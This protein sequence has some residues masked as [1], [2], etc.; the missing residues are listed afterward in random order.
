MHTVDEMY[1]NARCF[2]LSDWLPRLIAFHFLLI[3]IR[4]GVQFSVS[5][6]TVA[7]LFIVFL[8]SVLHTPVI[9]IGYSQLFAQ[10]QTPTDPCFLE[11]GKPTRCIPPFDNAAFGKHLVV[12]S[13]C[14][15]PPSRYCKSALD[16]DGELRRS[17]FICDAN[18]QKR[19]HPAAYMT[20]LNNP[21]NITC[22]MSEPFVEYPQNV[23]MT[24][25]LGKKFELTY[26]SLQ[27]CSTRPESMAIYKS[28]D[29]GETWTPF[30]YYSSNCKLMYDKSPR[31]TIS[32]ANEQAALCTE[33]YSHV[34][35]M[36]WARVAFSTLESRPSAYNFDNSP[37]LQDWVTATD[38]KVIFNRL[39]TYDDDVLSDKRLR[40]S[41]YYSLSDFA[42]G[43]RCKCN[44]H[45]SRCITNRDG[46]LVCDCKH[47]TD[48]YD[49]EVCKDFHYGKPWHRAT[50]NDAHACVGK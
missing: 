40:D 42:V 1:Y 19:R 31:A 22:W 34:N 37:V 50:S 18:N 10:Q 5:R 14:G 47:N 35:P 8:T 6:S 49:C 41:F 11:D 39:N 9:G 43:G 46:R 25:S 3:R 16:T 15:S 48:G 32:I 44:G 20:D 24:L 4:N 28:V 36:S 2:I 27:F 17:C 29:Y 26:I 33:A 38:I 12:S 21:N 30:Q 13:T 45:A 23:T 7:V